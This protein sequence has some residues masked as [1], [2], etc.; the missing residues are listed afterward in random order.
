L[1]ALLFLVGI[2]ALVAAAVLALTH[3]T[4]ED[5]FQ[6]GAVSVGTPLELKFDCGSV[7]AP[8]QAS[9]DAGML[10]RA[11]EALLRATTSCD[12]LL[13]ERLGIV[14]LAGIG[15]LVAIGLAVAIGVLTP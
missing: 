9:D 3:V 15:G 11:A 10:E 13:E 1:R 12:E 2:L 8:M 14:S 7:A 4:G 6:I 5:S